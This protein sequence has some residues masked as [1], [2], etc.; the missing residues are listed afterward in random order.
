MMRLRLL[1]SYLQNGIEEECQRIPSI[2]AVF[3]AEAS[4][5][6]LDT[7]HDHYSAI[8][9][10]IMRSSGANMKVSLLLQ[11]FSMFVRC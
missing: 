10:S 1:L 9:K 8:S 3:I 2:I 4:F 11:S 6:L 7:S 5:V